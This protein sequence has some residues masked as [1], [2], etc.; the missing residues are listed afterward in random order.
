[1]QTHCVRQ[2]QIEVGIIEHQGRVFSALGATVVGRHVTGYTRLVDGEIQL[3]TW[4]GQ[5]MLACRSEVVQR[6]WLG[7]LAL[8]FRLT[9]GRFIVGYTQAENGM[10]F[11]GELLTECDSDEARSVAR[12]LSH[13]FSDIDAKDEEAFAAEQIEEPLL[14]I[15]YCCPDCG[16]EWQ[17]QWSCAC[18]SQC[19]ACGMKNIMALTWEDADQ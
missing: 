17:E 15:S 2:G 18:D 4:C 11:R 3:S 5:T 7:S 19:P 8:M 13:R 1:M 10:L 16:H 12:R 14:N 9:G 6:F